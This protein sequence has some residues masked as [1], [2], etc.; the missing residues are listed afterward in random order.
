[1]FGTLFGSFSTYLFQQRTVRRAEAGARQEW[2][3]R[4][5]VAAYS[6]FAAALTELKR[7]IVAVWLSQSDAAAHMQLLDDAD[8]LGALA[9]TARF[10]LR[11]LSG[12]PEPLADTAFTH[13]DALRHASDRDEL[14]IREN[15]FE[16]AVSEFVTDASARLLGAG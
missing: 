6:E 5:R 15:E 8:R 9:E 11:L 4:E 14:K 12:G 13:I 3:R 7:A 2:L 1:M 16:S 10:R